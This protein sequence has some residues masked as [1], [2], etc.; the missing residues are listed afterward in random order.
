MYLCIYVFKKDGDNANEKEAEEVRI[1]RH[2][3]TF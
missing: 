1:I 2:N 3:I